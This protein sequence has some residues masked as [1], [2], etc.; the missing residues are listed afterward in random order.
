LVV[1]FVVGRFRILM[2]NSAIAYSN[3][4][5]VGVEKVALFFRWERDVDLVEG[6]SFLFPQ[7]GGWRRW[8]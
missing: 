4:D 8:M 5:G 2:K 1:F 7:E 6:W 3:G